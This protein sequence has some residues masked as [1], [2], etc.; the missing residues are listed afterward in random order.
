MGRAFFLQGRGKRTCP[1]SDISQAR[2]Q[3]QAQGL[4]QAHPQ[5]QALVHARD[6]FVY[7]PAM[8][9][10]FFEEWNGVDDIGAFIEKILQACE[11]TV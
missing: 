3:A 4:P 9:R 10:L 2:L 5:A 1:C 8:V 6:G 11:R 7:V